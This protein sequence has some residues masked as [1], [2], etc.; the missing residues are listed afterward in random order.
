MKNV[1]V[2]VV[3]ISLIA[4][5]AFVNV[6]LWNSERMSDTLS[7]F[8]LQSNNVIKFL[9]SE[10]NRLE[11]REKELQDEVKRLESEKRGLE[12]DLKRSNSIYEDA[13]N[14][15]NASMD[16]FE[17]LMH[18]LGPSINISAQ[19]TLMKRWVDCIG[20]GDYKGAAAIYP[21]FKA[22]IEEYEGYFKEHVKSLR[23]KGMEFDA[24]MTARGNEEGLYCIVT[25]DVKVNKKGDLFDEG[26]NRMRVVFSYKQAYNT[27]TIISI[28]RI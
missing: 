15:H 16:R 6:L 5:I 28:S 1:A 2:V 3:C 11:R 9:E 7:D 20:K 14:R 24:E 23:F 27:W 22:S 26:E 18:F 10:N 19:E 21:G 17:N 8:K 4:I 13:L 25:L 12:E